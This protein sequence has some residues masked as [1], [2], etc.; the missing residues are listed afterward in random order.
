MQSLFGDGSWLWAF[1]SDRYRLA[2]VVVVAVAIALA[3]CGRKAIQ[4]WKEDRADQR[5]HER[6]KLAIMAYIETQR[7]E[8]RAGRLDFDD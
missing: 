8:R 4:V 6:R 2:A 5:S 1:R 3:S 7:E